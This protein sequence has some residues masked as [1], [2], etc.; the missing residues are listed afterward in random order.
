MV[1]VMI[2]V[3]DNEE[4]IERGKGLGTGNHNMR[5]RVWPA[6]RARNGRLDRDARPIRTG[7]KELKTPYITID[8]SRSGSHRLIENGLPFLVKRRQD[9]D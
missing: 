1:L 4:D 2:I 8:L 3:R 7:R 6:N 5:V 9:R